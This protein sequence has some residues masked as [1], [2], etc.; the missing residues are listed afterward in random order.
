MCV[1]VCVSI[2]VCVWLVW[3]K[4]NRYCPFKFLF[5]RVLKRDGIEV[6]KK[7]R[8]GR[9]KEKGGKEERRKGGRSSRGELRDSIKFG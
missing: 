3:P 8:G 4:K 9:E 6:L 5:V 1:C 7:S 2:G